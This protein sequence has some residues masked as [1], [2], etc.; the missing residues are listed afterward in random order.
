VVPATY[1]HLG[2]GL[3]LR[4]QDTAGGGRVTATFHHVGVANEFPTAPKVSF[5]VANA[6]YLTRDRSSARWRVLA[7]PGAASATCRM[8]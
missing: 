5:L 3:Q 1:L 4:V 8:R 6:D 2:D 7:A